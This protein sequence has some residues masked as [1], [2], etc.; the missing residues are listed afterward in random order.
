M[1]KV[2]FT[3]PDYDVA[4]AYMSAYG[5][6]LIDFAEQN[7][8]TIQDLYADQATPTKFQD[9]METFNPDIFVGMGHGN[10]TTFTGQDTEPLII[11]GVNENIMSNKNVYLHSCATGIS[12]GPRMVETTCQAYYGYQAD[13]V[14]CFGGAAYYPHRVKQ[15][16]V[17]QPFFD[18]MLATGQAVLLGLEPEEVY[19]LTLERYD[20]WWNYWLKQS[21]PQTDCVLTWLNW[22]REAFIAISPE[23][24]WAG[25]PVKLS[26]Q[27][28]VLP[29]ATAA[30]AFYLFSKSKS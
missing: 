9:A 22:D 12:L 28:M 25:K 7:A 18:C 15:D 5:Q 1:A 13:F 14:F 10:A 30:F 6:D 4:T 16:P 19:R 3:R 24:L 8:H 11:A 29:L 27:G 21:H 20:Y 23:G 2:L 26:L 17:A